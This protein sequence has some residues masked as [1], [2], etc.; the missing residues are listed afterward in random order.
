MSS[1]DKPALPVGDPPAHGAQV[2][3]LDLQVQSSLAAITGGVSPIALSLAFQDW[4]LHL[5]TSPGK[6]IELMAGLNRPARGAGNARFAESGWSTWPFDV[7]AKT[8]LSTERFWQQATSDV[9]GVTPHHAQVV[10]FMAR[11]VLDVFS[12]SNF[13]WTNADVLQA[14]RDSKGGNLLSGWANLQQDMGLR[15]APAAAYIVGRDVAL[16]L[17]KVVY[18]NELVELI[19]YAPQSPTVYR[20][21]VLI[22]P[23]WILKYYILDLSPHNS[24]VRYLVEQGHTV[25]IISWRNPQ[26]HDRNL[27]MDDYLSV[28]LLDVLN[29]AVGYCLG[30]T[31]LAIAAAALGS[32]RHA[33]AARLHSVTLLAAQTDFS[34]P[35]E[36]GLFIDDSELNL[37]NAMM[38]KKGYLDGAQMGGSFQLLNARDL[39]WSRMVH[40]YML[41]IRPAPTDLATWNADTTRMPYRMHSE[42]LQRLFLDND[43]AE[44]RYCVDGRPVALKDIRTPLFVLGTERDQVAPW[45]SVYK[46]NLLSDTAVDFVL[47]SGGHNAGIVSEPGHARR[48]Y[49][50]MAQPAPG[51]AYVGPDEWLEKA[52][53][54]DGSWWPHWQQWLAGHSTAEQISPPPMGAGVT[55]ADA[56][57]R[58]VLGS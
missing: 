11:Q 21:P 12:P 9:H 6:Q 7:L 19:Q 16:T 3:L 24:L 46:I 40:Q 29:E 18:R 5:A 47:A 13:F 39:I 10:N 49:K 1:P 25:F 28:G 35:G 20:E 27:G 2:N 41:G 37:L 38:W 22:V 48:S 44:G 26:A 50:F 53:R 51:R 42:Y 30:G 15:Q 45:R 17:G 43:L 36:L 14:A 33:S 55:L 58:Y 4:F 56:P 8:F 34:E 32:G 23:S 57:G 54:A 31:L 52:Q